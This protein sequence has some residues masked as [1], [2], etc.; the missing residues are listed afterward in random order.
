M[1]SRVTYEIACT[2]GAV[3]RGERQVRHQVVNCAA[4]SRAVFVLPISPYD[5]PAKGRS[6]RAVPG[7]RSW[8][9]PLIAGGLSLVVLSVGFTFALPYLWRPTDEASSDEARPAK[10]KLRA[11]IDAGP[12]LLGQGKFH[13][14]RERL[15]AA[16]AL[17]TRWPRLLSPPEYRQLIQLHRQA[18]L[19]ARLSLHSVEEIAQHGKLVRDPEEWEAQFSDYRGRTILFEDVVRKDSDGRPV[20]GSHVFEVG[21]ETVR[22]ALEDLTVLSDLPL[23]ESPRLIFGARLRRCTREEGGGWVVRFEPDSGVLMTEPA[24]VEAC[25]S[26]P[27]DDLRSILQRQKRWLDEHAGGAPSRP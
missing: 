22:V 25:L 9:G 12:H 23:D 2:C 14:A 15:H 20:L 24:A 3:V 27:G 21:D 11:D 7:L 10:A 6:S 19:L 16:I 13:V 26:M 18:D 4:C 5:E 8:R 17:R 1:S